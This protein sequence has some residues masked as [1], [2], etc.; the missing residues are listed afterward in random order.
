MAFLF[1]Q[2]IRKVLFKKLNLEC[3]IAYESQE[4]KVF[5]SY[6]TS[7]WCVIITMTTVGYGD[8]FSISVFGRLISILNALWGAFIISCL[9][10]S[11]T[12]IIALSDKEKKVIAEIKMNKKREE[13]E[14]SQEISSDQAKKTHESVQIN[15]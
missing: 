7:I 9:V 4:V 11:M 15:Q 14:E 10:A 2:N 1:T 13:E 8:V 6:F 3:R 5:D 12:G